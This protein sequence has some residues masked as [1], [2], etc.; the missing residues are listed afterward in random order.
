MLRYVPGPPSTRGLVET[1][2]ETIQY[3]IPRLPED[4]RDPSW[5]SN[6][7]TINRPVVSSSIFPQSDPHL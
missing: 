4:V 3:I 7:P 5:A 6:L 1:I 2:F